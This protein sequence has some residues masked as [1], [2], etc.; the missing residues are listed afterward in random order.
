MWI[1]GVE[2]YSPAQVLDSHLG[3]LTNRFSVPT[4]VRRNEVRHFLRSLQCSCALLKFSQPCRTARM[5][6]AFLF[7][8]FILVFGPASSFSSSSICSRHS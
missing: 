4:K 1:H 7:S 5:D 3:A 2:K 6:V 8:R